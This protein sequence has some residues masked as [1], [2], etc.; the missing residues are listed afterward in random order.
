MTPMT[1]RGKVNDFSS[2]VYIQ[3]RQSQLCQVHYGK[4]QKDSKLMSLVK[5]VSKKYKHTSSSNCKKS[6]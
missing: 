6:E 3:G 4:G 1:A 5:L 2:K